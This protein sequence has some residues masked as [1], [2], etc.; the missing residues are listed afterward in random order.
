M[1]DPKKSGNQPESDPVE[2]DLGIVWRPTKEYIENS[3]IWRFMQRYGIQTFEELLRRSTD[4]YEWFWDAAAKDMEL[5]WYEPY[6]RIVDLSRGVP[7]ARWFPGG[8]YNYVHNAL[9]KHV[10]S[11]RRNKLAVIWEGEDGEVRKLSYWDLYVETNRLANALRSIGVEKGDRVGIFM[12]MIPEVVIATLACSKIGAIY[13]PIFSGYGAQAVA[14]RLEDCEAKVLITADGFYRRA[15]VVPMKETADAAAEMVPSLKHVVVAQRIGHQ[16]PWKEGRD[17]WW[18]ELVDGKSRQCETERTDAED[19][20]MIIY[21]SGTTGKPKGALHS[22]CGFPIKGTQDMAHCFDIQETD[23][24]F[25]FT[26]MGW[27]M[28]PWAVGGALTLGSTVFLYEGSPDYPNPDRVW[29][30]VERHG[31]TALGISPTVIRALMSHGEDWVKKHDLS[32][33]RILGS[34]GEPWNPG[35]YMW[36]FEKVGGKRCPIINY[37]GGTEISGGIVGCDPVQPIKPCSFSGPIPGM[38]ADVVDDEGK[39]VRGIVGELIIR[40]PWPGMTRGFWKDPARYEET[41]WSRMPGIWVHGDWA[42][43]DED[44]F[45]FIQGRSDD[46]IKV[47][48]K[49]VGPAEVESAAVS[50]TAVAE[51]AAIGVPHELKGETVVCFVV[52]RPGQQESEKLREEIKAV[53]AEHLG[54]ALK[55]DKVL[56]V[57]E[58]PKTR[59]AKV[60]RRVIKAKYLGKDPGDV[61]SLEN[62]AAVEE[63]GRAR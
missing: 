10:L 15:S 47:A 3:R 51:A 21:T 56:F 59:N 12:P 50:H 8:K 44:G 1:K 55:P 29:D 49:R 43:V 35:P 52:L 2:N 33:L 6:E 11:N 26:D 31:I 23:I 40:K 4:D 30:L 7:W 20:Y 60:M 53:I 61:S 27:M 36:F 42:L 28:G 45:W 18:H 14:A 39:S 17:L 57:R 38:D 58:L 19:L 41:Y 34:S 24:L 54:K 37:S 5:E 25:W 16:V 13:T 62:P 46:T 48:G 22:H 9:D 63:I 32:S